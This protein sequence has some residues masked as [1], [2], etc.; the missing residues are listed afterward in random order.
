MTIDYDHLPYMSIVRD[1]TVK[2]SSLDIKTTNRPIAYIQGAGDDVPEGLQQIGYNVDMLD[3]DDITQSI[4]SRYE[5]VITGV[6]AFNT[7]NSLA[8]KNKILFDWV[9]AGGTMI[10]QYNVNRGLVTTDIAPY[11]I[12]LSRDRITEEM[13]P[14]KILDSEHPAFNVPNKI[15]ETDFQGW[16]QERG[17]Y[18]PN[19]WDAAFTPLLEMN[20]TGEAPLKGSL[21]VAPYGEG[22]YVYSGLSWFRHIP[23]GVPGAYRLLSNLISLGYKNN[24]S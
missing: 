23:A 7:V 2:L 17:L 14:A 20:D 1:A 9:K 24:K 19:Q 15:D 16:V 12:T 22:Y 10:V 3:P 4:L 5:V 8:Y 18:F 6:R 13:A 21:L 11:P